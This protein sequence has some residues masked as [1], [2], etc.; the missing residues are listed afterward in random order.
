L[1]P[2]GRSCPIDVM[3]VSMKKWIM[4]TTKILTDPLYSV[5]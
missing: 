4:V 5:W 1:D 3:K 2:Q